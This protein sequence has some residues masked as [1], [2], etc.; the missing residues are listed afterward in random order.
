MLGLMI[1]QDRFC[2]LLGQ[3]YDAAMGQEE[4]PAVLG[5]LLTAVG[6]TCVALIRHGGPASDSIT[7][8]CD[9]ACLQLYESY[10]HRIDPIQPL[11]RRLPSGSVVDDRMLVPGRDLERTEFYND[12]L[13][14][15]DQ[16]GALSWHSQGP[17][18]QMATLK[19]LRS[20]RQLPFGDEETRLMC[21]L[22]PHLDRAQRVERRLHGIAVAPQSGSSPALSR[23][24]RE[25][26]HAIARGA[27]S[28]M[29]ARQLDLSTHTVTDYV[30]SAMRKLKAGSR[31]EAVATALGLG[32]IGAAAPVVQENR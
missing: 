27:S 18:R 4:W 29:I 3:T 13:S 20:R 9:P 11:L 14:R 22:A 23:R 30:K 28:K 1:T 26:L 24:E 25:C 6:G 21:A 10:Y 32:L 16:H 5:Q 7:V 2:H 17:G 31:T 15:W 8:G 12:F 19:I